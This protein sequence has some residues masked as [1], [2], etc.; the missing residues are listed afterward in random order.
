MKSK[1]RIDK[2]IHSYLVKTDIKID[3]SVTQYIH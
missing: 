1:I 3:L 2:T